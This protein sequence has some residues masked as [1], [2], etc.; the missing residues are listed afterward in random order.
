MKPKRGEPKDIY[1]K[2]FSERMRYL[3]E[4]INM[5]QAEFAEYLD[6]SQQTI[7]VWES[8]KNTPK[9]SMLVRIAEKFNVSIDWLF[10]K[11]MPVKIVYKIP[12]EYVRII[13]EFDKLNQTGKD[14]VYGY[15][16]DLASISTYKKDSILSA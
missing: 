7:N 4:S 16:G 6:C 9:M 3:R 10:G 11:E 13:G 14:K 5:T 1:T 15:I 8:A 2:K 12:D